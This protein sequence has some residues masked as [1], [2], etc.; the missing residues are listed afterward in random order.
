MDPLG[1]G[2]NPELLI[3]SPIFYLLKGDYKPY[4]P[5]SPYV[6]ISLTQTVHVGIWLLYILR[7]QKY[8]LYTYMDPLGKCWSPALYFGV[9]SFKLNVRKEGDLIIMG[10]LGKLVNPKPHKHYKPYVHTSFPNPINLQT[11]CSYILQNVGTLNLF[12]GRAACKAKAREV[13]C[14]SQSKLFLDDPLP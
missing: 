8:T 10:F 11:L 5:Y 12:V 14:T 2:W 4:K 9:S 6:H 3:R 1:T 7:P 13:P